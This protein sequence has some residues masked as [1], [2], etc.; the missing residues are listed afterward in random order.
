MKQSS[1]QK[2]WTKMTVRELA[3]ATKKFDKPIRFEDTQ[4]LTPAERARWRRARRSPERDR[5][6]AQF[7]REIDLKR[8]TKP[9]TPK[10]RA[11]HDRLRGYP[12]A[13]YPL[14]LDSKLLGQATRA[15]RKHGM[16]LEQF[17]IEGIRG[18]V[19]YSRA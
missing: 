9:L 13:V 2:S 18:M 19:A 14:P 3:E 8:E 11:I 5:Q 16:S 4:P 6:V 1:K 10:Q 7:D 12:H 17:I 15:A